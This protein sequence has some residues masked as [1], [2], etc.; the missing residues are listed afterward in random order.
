MAKAF[1]EVM[2]QKLKTVVGDIAAAETRRIVDELRQERSLF[3]KDRT[4]LSEKMKKDFAAAAKAIC[5]RTPIDTKANEAL[6][7]EQDNR[8][9]LLVSK[10][11]ANAILRIAASVGLVLSQATK[12][13]MTTDELGIPSYT[14]SFLTGEYLG[15]DAAGSLTG[16]TFNSANLIVK[17]WQ[18][19]FVVGNDLLA[20]ASVN[21]AD[22]L[23]SLGGEALAN[24]IDQQAFTGSGA[25]FVGLLNDSNVATFTMPSGETTFSSFKVIEDSSD[26]IASV[27]ESVLD[28]SAFYFERTVWAKL[29]SQKDAANHYILPYY[30]QNSGVLSSNSLGGG[31]KPVG[32][33]L[34]FPVY[35]C[36]HL[37]KNSATAVSTKFGV[38]GNFKG[39]AYGDKGE[40]RVAQFESGNFNGE[41][42]LKDQRAL[43][44]KHRHALVNALPAAFVAIKTA[45]S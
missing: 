41:I 3:G 12:W 17:K 26:V 35:T 5:L 16:L 27:E 39:F 22:W 9:G 15:I 45:A 43:V 14:G 11:V 10:E 23:L 40:M 13:D 20:D 21:L 36:R 38:F 2:E 32:E 1:D 18:L 44:Y 37:P 28:G 33:M 34:G 6:L 19:A 25:P 31:V 8:G 42:G 30:S 7:E 29:R 24:A 4:G